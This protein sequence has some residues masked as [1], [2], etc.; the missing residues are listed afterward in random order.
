MS[1]EETP[2]GVIYEEIINTIRKPTSYNYFPVELTGVFHVYSLEAKEVPIALV[3]DDMRK[4]QREQA[5]AKLTDEEIQL[6][7]IKV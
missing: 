1:T 4:V 7:G 2:Y 6:L 3:V 5:L